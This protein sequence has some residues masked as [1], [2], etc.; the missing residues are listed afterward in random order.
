M[1]RTADV[2]VRIYNLAGQVVADLGNR[3]TTN[4]E[5]KVDLSK[6]AA[7]MYFVRFIIDG[8]VVTRKLTL[9]K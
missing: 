9:T 5:Y 6:Y 2:N 3:T 8:N 4:Q 1:S 7:G